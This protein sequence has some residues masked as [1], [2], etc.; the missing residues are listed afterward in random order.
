MDLPQL[1][2]FLKIK[3]KMG[4][5]TSMLN[6]P[7]EKLVALNKP[8]KMVAIFAKSKIRQ[9]NCNVITSSIEAVS[10]KESRKNKSVQNANRSILTTSECTVKDVLNGTS[11]RLC[12][13]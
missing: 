9:S 4:V 1:S 8:S 10:L 2:K 12:Y 7:G 13:K 6:Q 5:P 3:L 11:K